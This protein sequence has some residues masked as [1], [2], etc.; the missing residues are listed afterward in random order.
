MLII[1]LD[2]KE[3]MNVLAVIQARTGSSRLPRK[4]LME[5]EGKPI[6]EHLINFLKF[7][8]LTNKIIVATSNLI[9]DDEIAALA[10]RND[11]DCYRGS[12]SDVLE[13]YYECA[14][15]FHGDVIVRLT[16]D[17]PLL[18]PRLVD[19][20]IEICTKS[21]CD[22]VSNMIHQTYPL[23]YLVEVMTFDLLESLHKTQHDKLSREHVTYHIRQHP[24]QYRIQEI[25]LPKHLDRHH[26][27]LTLDYIEDYKLIS[28]IFSSLYKPFSFIEY[29]RVV[30][31]L[32]SNSDLLKINSKYC[33]SD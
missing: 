25:C 22:Y 31:F 9:Q 4:I 24:E 18:D 8:K 13:R 33:H 14:K 16:S 26:W 30:E 23:G 1:A 20:A 2:P 11:V 27:R 28:K 15:K 10:I 6:L 32:D 21:N 12:E 17:C 3:I 7:S 29:E 19:K 5:I